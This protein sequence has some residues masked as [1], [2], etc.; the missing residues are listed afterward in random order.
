MRVFLS[1]LISLLISSCVLEPTIEVNLINKTNAI[2][3]VSIPW[4]SR[5]GGE[6]LVITGDFEKLQNPTIQIDGKSCQQ[7][8]KISSSQFS[9]ITPA[10]TKIKNVVLQFIKFN[11]VVSTFPLKYVG[12]LGQPTTKS[13]IQKSRGL[14]L[15]VLVKKIDSK[16]YI[17]DFGNKRVVGFNNITNLANKDFDFALGSS[18]TNQDISKVSIT[19][20]SFLARDIDYQNGLFMFADGENHRVLIFDGIPKESQ[21]PKIILGQPDYESVSVNN[22]GLSAKSL[23]KPMYAKFIDG[24]IFVTDTLNNRVLVWNSIPMS[25]FQDADYVLGQPNFTTN[26]ANT[27]GVSASSLSSPIGLEKIGNKLFVSDYDNRRILIWNSIPTS[28][29]GASQVMG[30]ADLTSVTAVAGANRFL[31]PVG[32]KLE[33]D[34]FFVL[35]SLANRVLVY[36]NF[37]INTADFSSLN[38]D[39][40]LGQPN[41]TTS[42]V[43][44][45]ATKITAQSLSQ[46]SKLEIFDGKLLVAD[47]FNNRI[48]IYNHIPD[49][50]VNDQHQAADE[51][52]G[53]ESMSMFK[54][55]RVVFD[56]R[57]TPKPSNISLHDGKILINSESLGRI[58]VWNSIPEDDFAPADF[59]LGQNGFTENDIELNRGSALPTAS[60][61]NVGYQILSHNHKLIVSDNTNNRI[62]IWNSLSGTNGQAADVVIGQSSFTTK[63]ADPVSEFTLRDVVGMD[64]VDNKLVVADR[65]NHRFLIYNNIPTTNN[66]PADMVVG[67][68]NFTDYLIYRSTP[69]PHVID[70][71]GFYSP[72]NSTSWLGKY[73]VADHNSLRVLLWN[74][75]DDFINGDEAVSVWG[76][77][78]LTSVDWGNNLGKNRLSD[79]N[80]VRVIDDVLYVMDPKNNRILE[81]KNLPIGLNL[82]PTGVIGQKD[83]LSN[84]YIN[85]NTFSAISM[86]GP[87]GMYSIDNYIYLADY[88]NDRVI[89][90]P[91]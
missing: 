32:V 62:L 83:Y 58:S 34:K 28:N 29:V 80:T 70:G 89:I 27:G 41:F 33:N 1:I 49:H 42:T 60:T 53:Q 9:C 30:Q 7:V 57:Y 14:H 55:N 76:Q 61:L 65:G 88:F 68:S 66:A 77:D 91:K 20:G 73:V 64:I 16:L 26:T 39:I 6:E 79:F 21:K 38:A 48:L 86:A 67:Q 81:F 13:I 82:V 40:V 24:K 22:G 10:N 46:P 23:N 47:T 17:G 63:V 51:V 18:H 54:Q 69:S 11:K 15:P 44:E 37:D 45:V 75:F 3:S 43:W 74:S 50:V 84:N 5:Q 71:K 25:N 72:F 78:D 19:S 36:K 90:L 12:I 59:V 87:V 56:A 8:K 35:D 31:G 2:S 52:I 4:L 85:E